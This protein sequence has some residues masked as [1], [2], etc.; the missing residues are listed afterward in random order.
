MS[1]FR[2]YVFDRTARVVQSFDLIA[3]ELANAIARARH[4]LNASADSAGYE[5]WQA[6]RRKLGEPARSWL[7]ARKESREDAWKTA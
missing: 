4:E 1:Y 2:L 3:P 6:T 5:L 7:L